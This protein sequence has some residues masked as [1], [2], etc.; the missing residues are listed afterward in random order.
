MENIQISQTFRCEFD[1]RFGLSTFR[2]KMVAHQYLRKS[3]TGVL[4]FLS[5]V[6]YQRFF[7]LMADHTYDCNDFLLLEMEL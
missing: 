7:C 2:L 6:K 3:Q 1:H 5:G 4:T